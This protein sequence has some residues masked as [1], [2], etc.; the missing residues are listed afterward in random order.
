[1][2]RFWDSERTFFLEPYLQQEHNE[3]P[4]REYIREPWYQFD[5]VFFKSSFLIR[6]VER[7][8]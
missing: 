7:Y 2:V 6:I 8:I 5:P 1:M 4:I 3:E